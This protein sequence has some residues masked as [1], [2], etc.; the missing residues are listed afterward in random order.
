MEG[1]YAAPEQAVAVLGMSGRFPGA[2]GVPELWDLLVAGRDGVTEASAERPWLRELYAAEPGVPGK[3]PTVRGGFLPG[4]DL[5][6]AGFFGI[7]PRE[8][9]RM[10]PQQRLLLET[11]VEAAE[12][13]AVPVRELSRARTGVFLGAFGN[14][15]WLRQIGDL[16]TLDLLAMQ[17]GTHSALH[18]R[19]A[20]ALNLRGPAMTIDTA[21]SSSLVSV[22]AACQSL[23]LGECDYALAGGSHVLLAPYGSVPLARAGA[24]GPDGRC[25]FGDASANGY[26]QSE[27]VGM[28]LL[29]PLARALADGDRVRAVILGGALGSSGF[30]GQGMIAPSVRSQEETLRLAYEFAGVDPRDARFVEAH[31]TGT[32]VGD[33]VELQA[34]ARVLGPR[35][36]DRERCLVGSVKTNIGHPEAAAGVVGVIKTVLC[37][38]HR[39]VPG[40]TRLATANPAVDWEAAPLC[41][42]RRPTAL[43]DDERPLVAGV[44]SIGASGVAAHLVLSAAPGRRGAVP[45]PRP[46]AGPSLLPLSAR[47]SPALRELA[48][49]YVHLLTSDPA[50]CL[51]DVCAS[52]ATGRDHHEHRLA[53]SAT[54]PA[55]LADTLRAHLAGQERREVST[56]NGAVWS[57]PRVVF[58]LPGQGSQWAGMGRRLLGREAVFT[59]TVERCDAVIRIHGGWSL[60]DVLRNDDDTWLQ[61]TSI[62]QPALWAMGVSLAALWRSWGIEPDAVLGHSQGEI[63]AAQVA[64]ALTLEEAGRVSCLRAGLIDTLAQ[65]GA[66]CWTEVP[67]SKV[68]GFLEELGV[69]ASVAVKESPTS[70]VL[71][72]TPQAIDRIEEGCEQQGISCLRVP[73]HY[74]AHSPSVDP[75][76]DPLRRQLADLRPR[77]TSVPFLSTV[78]GSVVPGTTL[79]GDYWWRNLRDPVLLDSAVRSL[80]AG[81]RR[82]V[83]LQV[84]PHPVLTPA[85]GRGGALALESL[86]RDQDEL[87]SLHR[88]L[89]ALY[90]AGCDP[91]W[92]QVLGKPAAP[93]SLPGYPWQR[94][95]YWQQARA[96]PWPPIQSATTKVF[97]VTDAPASA[98]PPPKTL[99]PV[100]MSEEEGTGARS[101]SGVLDREQ[102]AYL[103]DH[104][105]AERPV[106]PGAFYLEC[107]LAAVREEGLGNELRDVTFE[108]L[109]LLDD[110]QPW[111]LRVRV[112]SSAEDARCLSVTSCRDEAAAWQHHVTLHVA[113]DTSLPPSPVNL[114][115]VRERCPDWQAG[116]HFYQERAMEGNDWRGPFRCVAEIHR[117]AGEAL[118]RLRPVARSGHL[119][120]PGALDG[121]LQAALAAAESDGSTE[122]GFV[123]TA[124]DRLR[125]YREPEAEEL[126]VHASR[127]KPDTADGIR[128][129]LVVADR[130]GTV[131]A[132]IQGVRG[133]RLTP[134]P[135]HP[136][137]A[138]LVDPMLE[139][140]W[141]PLPPPA[142]SRQGGN[143]LLLSG[144]SALDQPLHAALIAHGGT[145]HTVR[146]GVGYRVH[147]PGRFRVNLASA[148]D[149]A[150]LLKDITRD[151][152]LTGVVHLGALAGAT[153]SDAS[154]REVQWVTTDLCASLLPVSR[155]LAELPS[156][157]PPTLFVITRGAQAALADDSLP[158]P[159]Q[160]ALWPLT[161]VLQLETPRSPSVLIDLDARAP[162]LRGP[163]ELCEEADQ[164]ALHLYAAGDEDRIALRG[165]SAHVPRLT[166]LPQRLAAHPFGVTL[167]TTG[168]IGG[169]RLTRAKDNPPPGPGQIAIQVT[170][171]AL[172]YRDVLLAVGMVAGQQEALTGCECA[173]TV[174]AV[175]E[176]VTE[177][178]VGDEVCALTF[179]PPASYTITLAAYTVA[180][181]HQLTPAEAASVPVAY[182][183]AYR[184]LI[185]L[186]RLQPGQKVLIHSASGGMGMAAM[187][188]A[189][190]CGARVFATA[191]T[192]AKRDLLLRMGAEKVA[193]SRSTDFARQLRDADGT[194]VD[195]ILNTLK[196]ADA[197][198]ANFDLLA[199]FGHYVE[200][201]CNEMHDGQ[202]FP[203]RL[204]EPGRSYHA[205]NLAALH[206]HDPG[207]LGTTLQSVIDLLS[208]GEL[209][210][211]PVK[212]FEA[213]QVAQAMSLMA[214]AEHT[215]K[216]ALHF[217][218]P[219]QPRPQLRPDATYLVVGGLSGIGGLFTEWLADN[220]ARHLLVTGRTNLSTAPPTDPRAQR[221]ARLT[222]RPD[223]DVQYAAVD[224]ADEPAM[225]ALLHERARQGLPKVAGVAH[226]AL[227]LEPTPLRDTTKADIERTLRPKVAGGWTL[228]RLFPGDDLD[229][230][231]LFS[232][233]VSPLSGM[234]LSSQLGA[235][236]AA[237][238]FLD[239]LGAH[240]RAAGAPTTVVNWGYWSETGM[241]HRL[242]ER[243][244]RSV[245]PAGILP[246][247]PAQAPE[248]FTAVLAADNNLCCIPADWHTY[249]SSSPQDATDPLLKELLDATS[250]PP[251]PGPADHPRPATSTSFHATT[252]TASA[253]ANTVLESARTPNRPSLIPPTRTPM[254]M[255]T[256]S[257]SPT[258]DST[259]GQ[260]D[261]TPPES[262][263]AYTAPALE[264]WLTEQVALVLDMPVNQVDPTQPVN[265]LGIDSLLAAELTTRLRREHSCEITVPHLLKAASLRTL[266]AELLTTTTLPKDERGRC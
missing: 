49:R 2:P 196:G 262:D 133:K 152:P 137:A 13:A 167:A 259:P 99:H 109:L 16:E 233:A 23:R 90:A 158:A 111:N 236:A 243:D 237:N 85:L 65:P 62:I 22:H 245:L 151:A 252:D 160:A 130:H 42:P 178:A 251:P 126:W 114:D 24:I 60:C 47:S 187:E 227:A 7:S 120:H 119:I 95:S 232:S 134:V 144:G 140:C 216:L 161:R 132:E 249:A 177:F 51:A 256:V 231:V 147:G 74:A 125:L 266:A 129:D 174:V 10:D 37:L 164:L 97:A 150:R 86:R 175:G 36:G 117:G 261:G 50:P 63:A 169:I 184:A 194:G 29:K 235:Y 181:P 189:R 54:T 98:P 94:F 71:A 239:A 73:V 213:E 190:W 66:L 38:E 84:S 118:V 127:Q 223:L 41:L 28:L 242:S 173:G 185:D 163:R 93:V 192:Q 33:P 128:V 89:G 157:P 116:E 8:A 19:I 255:P 106:V 215:G 202:P 257:P 17:G 198:Q 206:E 142:P 53:V 68:A 234:R 131:I 104:R 70:S 141:R 57:T 182:V 46:G 138:P 224:V 186:A 20:Y 21:C 40:D 45:R 108:E 102:H 154:P 101:W 123:L 18:G 166:A 165:G 188:I 59:D 15:Y 241:A 61:Q 155:A 115:H 81:E 179:A 176:G 247:T 219:G 162:E 76:R 6:D 208:R 212:V 136:P 197:R 82:T 80:L 170:H 105:I 258:T 12:D 87:A 64:G 153:G 124:V 214:R 113:R 56:S 210:P 254:R 209:A 171:T 48:E 225:T 200:A 44:T 77:E 156:S 9:R 72:G 204:F 103:L 248:L 34:L 139:V 159:W 148:D 79:N 228:H 58:V 92:R 253:T 4:L 211:L 221:M 205:M 11:S 230:F 201:A 43:A 100:L 168:G 75:V 143:W 217:P 32:V 121:C 112:Q 26:V 263:P 110:R 195:I 83:F 52:A 226:S 78:T 14:D 193:D 91:N 35:D 180:R 146:P 25:K 207:A 222:Q 135:P 265:R 67:P 238:A 31:G 203:A 3:L 199:P 220:G 250:Q 229:F 218:P 55:S 39:L 149:L 172:N 246:I 1:Q 27:A 264:R 5:F 88:T 244:G 69:A 122:H 260:R 107:A 30:T 191:G 183:S 145:V 240:R 96:F